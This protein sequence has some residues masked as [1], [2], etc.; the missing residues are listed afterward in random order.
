MRLPDRRSNFSLYLI[1]FLF[2][3]TTLI[4]TTAA[5]T[6]ISISP[7]EQAIEEN[8]SFTINIYIEPDTPISGVQFDFIFNSSLVNVNNIQEKK[9]LS[10][11]GATTIFNAGS[12]DNSK[13]T[14]TGV[15]SLILGKNTATEPGTLSAINLVSNGLPGVCKLQL[16]NVIVSNSS[17]KAVPVTIVNGSVNVGD[18][19]STG[20]SDN[21]SGTSTGERSGGGGGID[22]GENYENIKL[23]EVSRVYVSKETVVSYRFKASE[24]PVSYINYTALKNAGFITTTIEVLENTSGLVSGKP[25][26][27]VYKNLN[28]WVGKNGYSTEE[29]IG[30]PV[31]GFR[32]NKT[33]LEENRIQVSTV[34][35]NRYHLNAWNPLPTVKTGEDSEYIFFESEAPGFSPFVI[36][37]Q[38]SQFAY[39]PENRLPDLKEKLGTE[40]V[41]K[42][43]S[44][45][46]LSSE[47]EKETVRSEDGQESRTS[48]APGS[49]ISGTGIL[50]LA[51]LTSFKRNRK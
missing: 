49:G 42:E 8:E 1:V 47:K 15:Y 6:I 38:S 40:P 21:S 5:E 30:N 46:N 29:N 17:G 4:G 22:N 45:A 12:I 2:L 51:A 48:Q 14:V 41:V 11:T 20:R 43:T 3:S 32:V 37:G 24:N 34:K 10:Q 25:G 31:I 28:I 16:S 33:W 35:L 26:G 27:I 36:T 44:E 7:R 18:A 9:A 50:F 19:E 39:G 13:G 23:K